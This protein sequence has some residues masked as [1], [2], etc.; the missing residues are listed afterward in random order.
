[1]VH[2]YRGKCSCGAI[3]LLLSLENELT[4]YAPRACDCDFCTRRNIEYLSEP[5]AELHITYKQ[6]LQS[7]QQGSKQAD[8]LACAQCQ[9]V[10]AVVYQSDTQLIGA[11]NASLLE[12]KRKCKPAVVVSPKIL[13]AEEKSNRWASLWGRVK[14][15]AAMV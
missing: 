10:I 7:L 4:E 6:P 9:N 5:T 1:M 15:A 3:S 12:D 14:V 11:V 13:S 8:F 2:Q